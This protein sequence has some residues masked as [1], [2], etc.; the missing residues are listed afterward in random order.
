MVVSFSPYALL[1]F[2]TGIVCVFSGVS[3]VSRVMLCLPYRLLEFCGVGRLT[4]GAWS[5]WQ[6]GCVTILPGESEFFSARLQWH[7]TARIRHNSSHRLLI[8]IR[9]LAHLYP[10]HRW[11][12]TSILMSAISDIRHRH[13]L[14]RNRRQKCRTENCHSDIGSAPISTSESIPISDIHKK[15]VFSSSTRTRDPGNIRRAIYRSATILLV[16]WGA[17]RITDKTSFRYPI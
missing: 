14:F 5:L 15:F 3:Q 2:I 9:F 13:L 12:S 4:S 10:T 16:S 17:C 7:L 1:G 8:D 11:A 6:L